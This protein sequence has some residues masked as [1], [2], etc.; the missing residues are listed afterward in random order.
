MELRRLCLLLT[1]PFVLSFAACGDNKHVPFDASADTGSGSDAAIDAP[2]DALMCTG[3]GQMICNNACVNTQTDSNNCGTCG[4]SCGTGTC[5]SGLCCPAGQTN[6]GGMC[7]D[8]TMDID[9]C[10]A[11][12][13][14]CGAGTCTT[15][16]GLTTC[17]PQGQTNCNGQCVDLQSS[18]ANCGMCGMACGGTDT[19]CTG[20]CKDT[21]SDEANCGM[22]GTTCTSGD[23]CLSGNP[24]ACCGNG[25]ANCSGSCSLLDDN[26]NCGACGASCGTGTSCTPPTGTGNVACCTASQNNC[27]GS[28]SDPTTDEA[29]CGGCAGAGGVACATGETCTSG[30]CCAPGETACN[31]VCVDTITDASNCGTCG[32]ACMGGTPV[33]N[34]GTCAGMCD[35]T[36]TLCSGDCVNTSNDPNNCG[37]CAGA[38]G[39]QCAANQVCD[40]GSCTT[41]CDTGETNCNGA[42]VNLTGNPGDPN[43]CGTCSTVCPLGDECVSG[44]CQLDCPPGQQLCNGS[45]V[46]TQ[47]DEGNCGG[48]AGSGGAVCGSMQTCD[49][50]IC[51]GPGQENVGGICCTIG[52]L[53]CGGACVNPDTNDS[54]CGAC[55]AACGSGTTCDDGICCGTGLENCSGTSCTSTQTD[56]AHCG[57]CNAPCATT[58]TC[59]SGLC[60]DTLT[61]YN[62]N[63]ICCP[64]GSVNCNGV[65]TNLDNPATCGT[66]CANAGPCQ[67]GEV[68]SNGM[69]TVNCTLPEV[70]CSGACVD[71][72]TD[73][74]NCGTCGNICAA[75]Q[76]CTGGVC[77]AC[78]AGAPSECE[79]P[80]NACV[81]PTTDT[82]NCGEC[83]NFCAGGEHCSPS[84]ARITS[85]TQSGFT[86]TFTTATAHFLVAGDE[87]LVRNVTIAGYNGAWRV[88]TAPT[89]T[90][91][92]AVLTVQGLGAATGQTTAVAESGDCCGFG[93]ESCNGMCLDFSA[94][95]ANCGSCGVACGANSV[96]VNGG[97]QCGFGQIQCGANCITPSI[98]P[99][100]CGA[101]GNV[102]GVGTN[103]GKP[104]CVSGGCIATCPAPLTGCPI[105]M[106]G[107]SECVNTDSDSDNCGSCGNRCTG[108]TGCSAGSCVPKVTLGMDPAKCVGGGPP[109][110]VPDDGGTICTGNLGAT[111][112]TFGL[113]ARTN[114]G[115]ISRDLFTDAFDST[116]GPYVPTCTTDPNCGPKRCRITRTLCSTTADCAVQ[117]GNDCDFLVK[118]IGG[119]CAGG[120]VG[121]N[122][123]DDGVTPP[124]QVGPVASTTGATHVG[125]AFW[126]FG[127]IG[128][129]V[130]GNTQVK[131]RFLNQG[132]LDLSKSTHLWGEATV[133]GIWS[134]GGNTDITIDKNLTVVTP[135]TCPPLPANVLT[136]TPPATCSV[137]S[138]FPTLAQPCGTRAQL[139]DVKRIVRHYAQPAN[140]DNALIGLNQNVLDDPATSLRIDLP[141]G[142]YYF[143]SIN[144]GKPVTIVVNG[145]TAII[146]GGAIRLAQEVI[147]DVQ[148]NASLDIFAGGVLNVSNQTTL[149]S[150]AYPRL[151]RLYLGDDSCRGGG[152]LLTAGEDFTD[153]CSGTVTAGSCVGGGGNLGQTISLSQGGNFNGLL[154][155]GYGTFTHSNPLEMYGSI[156]T[157]HFDA[158]GDTIVHYDNGAVKLG[159]ECP[160]PSGACESCRDCNN[161]ACV[162]NQCGSCTSDSQCCPPLVC[163]SGT[164]VLE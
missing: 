161:Q 41:M 156:F 137:A 4:N 22:C 58:E 129:S 134:S 23:M 36:E 49:D 39:T 85:A 18:E 76:T 90:T 92:T 8:L 143:N 17:C 77:G 163:N 33:C 146:V 123:I 147:F 56:E 152:S 81:N 122:G 3:A 82:A 117:T 80:I 128:L 70:N 142:V 127:T 93:L 72:A 120:G 11:C 119:R 96:C 7:V 10:G 110:T 14:D 54:H 139:I 45:C 151:T 1:V 103:A 40:D 43:H 83:G 106:S 141:C 104:F 155:G 75:G 29:N 78:P 28:C 112:F 144:A 149:G 109:I 19:C 130:K 98:D 69:C 51:C 46:N 116:S 125:G 148:P 48:C 65:C 101:C 140:N 34:G 57:A 131:Q 31:G 150:P 111:S 30:I 154:W 95:P 124:V 153:C 25:E 94:D 162:N 63:G 74:N 157:N 2:P 38:G 66:T 99:L 105:G 16:N 145:R 27:G 61:E 55:N 121:V 37:G 108:N 52:F 67:P 15:N 132:P 60:C 62:A 88:A 136:L 126:V 91:F 20:L 102:C 100:N 44:V 97:C 115:P 135:E 107:N 113:C 32:N 42:C 53:N 26:T 64:L 79:P 35:P 24:A 5:Q 138:A 89:A 86:A 13:N 21:Q 133:G 159:E 84:S 158:S 59:T 47:S 160:Q 6:C 118:C 87:V 50:G 114:I 73:E 68:C 164:C 9:H 12:N 71:R